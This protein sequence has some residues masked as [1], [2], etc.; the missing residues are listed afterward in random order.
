MFGL[1]LGLDEKNSAIN[2]IT[3]EFEK[4]STILLLTVVQYYI[5]INVLESKYLF[6]TNRHIALPNKEL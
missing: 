6:R 1:V 3:S 4:K 2:Y 5:R